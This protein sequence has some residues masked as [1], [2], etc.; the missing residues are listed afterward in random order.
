MKSF[1]SFVRGN[2][3]YIIT[4]PTEMEPSVHTEKAVLGWLD[5]LYL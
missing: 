4:Y 3:K 5:P 2:K 1:P